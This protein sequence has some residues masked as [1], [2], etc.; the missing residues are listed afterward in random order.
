MSN[1]VRNESIGLIYLDL[2]GFK[3]V[4][5]TLGHK[6]GDQV[7][8]SIA[9]ILSQAVRSNDAVGRLGG[10]E[11]AIVVNR[12]TPVL[13]NNICQRIISMCAE[14]SL[15]ERIMANHQLQVSC[16]LG[17]ALYP[18][19]AR[20]LQELVE[21]ADQAMF[22]AKKSGKNCYKMSFRQTGYSAVS[23]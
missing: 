6:A 11:F 16:S 9:V 15:F 22:E 8:R 23:E 1:L 21:A 7:L 13:L 2:D 20:S 4:N 18:T 17:Y 14:D 12:A 5:D 3:A 10:D 19:N